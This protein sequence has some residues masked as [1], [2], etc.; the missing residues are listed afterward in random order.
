M[1]IL[2]LLGIFLL[3]IIFF[4]IYN[5]Y[6]FQVLL[7][8]NRMKNSY[9][10]DFAS[11]VK[12]NFMSKGYF[13]NTHKIVTKENYSSMSNRYKS[14]FHSCYNIVTFKTPDCS[15]ELFFYLISEGLSYREVMAIRAFPKKNKI[16]SEGNVEKNYS[17]LNIFTNNRYLTGILEGGEVH[18]CLNWLIRHNDDILLISHNSV[19]FK[20]FLNKSNMSV[21]RTMDM[22]KALNIIQKRIYKEDIIEY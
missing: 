16:R 20:A 1:N 10:K 19:Y 4:V 3:L 9:I 6:S 7:Y 14:S 22:V 8:R 18:D 2:M 11:N 17:R 21:S 15:W 13:A 12:G 5:S